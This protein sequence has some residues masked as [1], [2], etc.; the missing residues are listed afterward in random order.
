MDSASQQK[1]E[2]QKE[3]TRVKVE[4]IPEI[5]VDKDDA[6]RWILAGPVLTESVVAGSDVIMVYQQP[7]Q[8]LKYI[9]V[10]GD[11]QSGY[12]TYK[13]CSEGTK[14]ERHGRLVFR[15]VATK[16]VQIDL[17]EILDGGLYLV[18]ATNPVTGVDV[19]R[20]E[21]DPNES[22]KVATLALRKKLRVPPNSDMDVLVAGNRVAVRGNTKVK[23][24][25]E[26]RADACRSSSKRLRLM[27]QRPR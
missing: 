21:M 14:R 19:A 24:V 6:R 26:V 4:Y 3:R 11:L 5:D 20:F 17:V 18:A 27:L 23:S 10:S 13:H 9:F 8:S 16:I 22:W 15:T 2:M 25:I 7:E 1:T 12:V